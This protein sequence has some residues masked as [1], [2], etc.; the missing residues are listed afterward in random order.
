MQRPGKD[1]RVA[2]ELLRSARSLRVTR[3]DPDQGEP[4]MTR[5]RLSFLAVLALA[6]S[7]H[8]GDV[9]RVGA[10]QPYA[11]VQAAVNAASAGDL[12]LVDPG[13][14]PPFQVGT[15]GMGP[16]RLTI[17][18]SSGSYWIA[19]APGIPEILVENI[20]LAGAVTIGGAH[21]FYDDRF[22]PAVRVR[23]CAGAVRMSAL[24]VTLDANLIAATVSAA[25]EV[26]DAQTF[27][28]SDSSIW[29]APG[30]GYTTSV[31]TAGGIDNDGISGLQAVD[32]S[33]V[34]QSSRLSGYHNFQQAGRA[35][36][37]GDGARFVGESSFW[38][39]KNLAAPA[40]FRGGNGVYG[41]HSIHQVRDPVALPLNKVCGTS[42]A[43]ISLLRGG[44]LHAP[45]G[46]PGGYYGT[47]NSNGSV[48]LGSVVVFT[49]PVPCTPEHANEAF[50]ANPLVS[51]GGQLDVQIYT[52]NNRRY[53]L[54][55]SATTRHAFGHG[56]HGRALLG[57]N[58]RVI[59]VGTTIARVPLVRSFPI[60][61]D[62]S[63]L[64]LQF[65]VQA[66]SGKIGSALDSLSLP[67]LA[68]IGP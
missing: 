26:E 35:G 45:L 20:P 5:L 30:V 34:I 24:D 31:R 57:S 4:H 49:A 59:D 7:T 6:A 10:G 61:A 15:A 39:L 9:L 8:A 21:I 43:Q 13:T 2:S 48:Q 68:V 32:S 22:A 28:L 60:P 40:A 56:L 51:L 46:A 53:A 29:G 54:A 36:C 11:D 14:Y 63:F 38:L 17:W 25:V 27:W 42:D 58:A 19:Q 47:N 33:G 16:A 55:M 62:V 18:P 64:G 50:V 52:R 1:A 65:S 3:G 67:S 44:Q 37:G 23:N 41:G 66:L 12:V